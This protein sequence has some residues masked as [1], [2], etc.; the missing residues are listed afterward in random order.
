MAKVYKAE[1]TRLPKGIQSAIQGK[2]WPKEQEAPSYL[3][4]FPIMVI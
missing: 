1:I 3:N 2:E 4:F